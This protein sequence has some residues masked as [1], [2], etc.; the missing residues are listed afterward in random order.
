MKLIVIKLSFLGVAILGGIL[1]IG[2]TVIIFLLK[3]YYT[4]YTRYDKH[5]LEK[6]ILIT[7]GYIG[8]EKE[9]KTL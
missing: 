3:N 9:K 1:L 4:K 2:L 7:R 6:F 8:H 5:D